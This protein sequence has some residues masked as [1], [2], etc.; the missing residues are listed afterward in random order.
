M[1]FDAGV[2]ALI[3]LLWDAAGVILA[4]VAVWVYDQQI[5]SSESSLRLIAQR[6]V[7]MKRRIN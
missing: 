4:A 1:L 6:T 7:I 5:D 2:D 3:E